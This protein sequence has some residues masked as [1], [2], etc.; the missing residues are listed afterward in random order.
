MRNFCD[1]L[2]GVLANLQWAESEVPNRTL[3]DVSYPSFRLNLGRKS[4]VR[5]VKMLYQHRLTCTFCINCSC[6]VS[7]QRL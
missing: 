4:L 3:L 5:D 7:C 1:G 6:I 2:K